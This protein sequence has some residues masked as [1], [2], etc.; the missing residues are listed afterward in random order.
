MTF[1]PYGPA[2]SGLIYTLWNEVYSHVYFTEASM[3]SKCYHSCLSIHI[4]KVI[5]IL[6]NSARIEVSCFKARI[7]QETRLSIAVIVQDTL[8]SKMTFN[9]IIMDHKISN[10]VSDG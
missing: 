8:K 6:V 9:Y 3:V 10:V 7:H 1:Q 4:S 5:W 2:V